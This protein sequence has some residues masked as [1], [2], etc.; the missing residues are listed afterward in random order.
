MREHSDHLHQYKAITPQRRSY[1]CLSTGCPHTIPASLIVGRTAQCPTC[2]ETLTVTEEHIKNSLIACK[3]C[4]PRSPIKM[5]KAALL[6]A[7]AE[8]G[9]AADLIRRFKER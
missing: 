8:S 3:G 1:R 2:G 5:T 9:E 7:T 4:N 6:T